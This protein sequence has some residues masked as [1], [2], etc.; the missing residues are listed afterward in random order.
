[1]SRAAG[2]RKQ[3]S[4][5]RWL[6]F[7]VGVG[8]GG[9]LVVVAL[10]WPR[11]PRPEELALEQAAYELYADVLEQR[12]EGRVDPAAEQAFVETFGDTRLGQTARDA[13]FDEP[14][15][16][17][18]VGNSGGDLNGTSQRVIQAAIDHVAALGGGVVELL[19]GTFVLR[20]SLQL[21]D[22]VVL[23]GAGEKTVLSK[24]PSAESPLLDDA[25]WYENRIRVL[26]PAGFQVGDGLLLRARPGSG[27]GLGSYVFAQG[28]VVRIDGDQLYLRERFGENFRVAHS[29]TA[30]SSFSMLSVVDVSDV[31]IESLTLD[32]DL[33]HNVFFDGNLGGAVFSKDARRLWIRDVQTRN[34]AGD[35]FSIQ[36]SVDVRIE[37][38]SSTGHAKFG[39]HIGGGS[40]R[41]QLLGSDAIKNGEG[42][43]FC[44]GVTESVVDGGRFS[45]NKT[46]GG[47]LGHRDTNNVIKNARFERNAWAAI[48]FRDEAFA[49]V[50]KGGHRNHLEGNTFRNNN[51]EEGGWAVAVTAGTYDVTLSGNTF[52]ND[53]NGPQRIGIKVDPEGTLLKLENNHFVGT[54]VEVERSGWPKRKLRALVTP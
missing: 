44:W 52:E 30:F 51:A 50:A 10:V 7:A 46:F 19:P 28:T 34:F 20:D 32:G 22:H 38:C 27:K 37:R 43:Y 14:T 29:A 3:G 9:A 42:L 2:D 47:T 24:A 18:R 6:I 45:E 54:E 12:K 15:T 21:R 13:E 36:A 16:H 40:R 35:G 4:L 49:G 8:V 1:M 23:R 25:D 39:Y 5:P 31:R 33:A 53:A 11:Q 41:V 26:R 48:E 17:V